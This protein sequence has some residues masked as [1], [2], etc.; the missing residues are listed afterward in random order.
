M[1]LETYSD[2]ERSISFNYSIYKQLGLV[3]GPVNLKQD[4]F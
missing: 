2:E 4:P 1:T 3:I